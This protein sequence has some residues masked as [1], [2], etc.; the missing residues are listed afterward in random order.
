MFIIFIAHVPYN[1]W[2]NYIPA[3]FGPSDATEMFVFCSGFASAI[4]FGSVFARHGFWL[5]TSRVLY[6]CW[7]IY[8][9]HI[10]LFLI[11]CFVNI[12]GDQLF[13]G[14]DYTDQLNLWPFFN[15]P[16]AGLLHLM[17]L[18]YV[19]NYFDILPMYM[20]ILLMLPL[21]M[22]LNRLHF[23]L[24][25][26]FCGGLYT[27]TQ[28]FALQLPAEWWSDRVWFFNPFGWQLIFY[29]GFIFGAKWLRL[30]L[31][32]GRV[33]AAALGFAILMIVCFYSPIWNSTPFLHSL[34]NSFFFGAF[35]SNFGILR[36]LHFVSLAYVVL[37]LL[38]GREQ[39]LARPIFQ[40][41]VRVG[42]QALVTF[43]AS[44]TLSW[45]AGMALDQIGRTQGTWALV[46]LTG[47]VLL[48]C[49]AYTA[50]FVKSEPW[51]RQPET[52]AS[53]TP[54]QRDTTAVGSRTIAAPG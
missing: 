35:K 4:A 40:P 52:P 7:Q 21:I 18:T 1:I 13:P 20:V 49:V 30:P 23:G 46:N 16:R 6:R 5:G 33:F 47:F 12:V 38:H 32:D 2:N 19:P 37:Y 48:I 42:Q 34:S 51:R 24:V 44:M 11:L 26:L 28:I 10:T 31:A 15:D 54:P 53:A 9:A 41:I 45:I 39:I 8:W 43:M 22:L 3:R 17:T 36:W 29:T 25:L 50:R 27:A 14:H